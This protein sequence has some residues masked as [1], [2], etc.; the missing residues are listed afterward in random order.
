VWVRRDTVDFGRRQRAAISPLLSML[1][2]ARKHA[3]TSNPRAR[4]VT[5]CRSAAALGL[6]GAEARFDGRG[7]ERMLDS[8]NL[9]FDAAAGRSRLEDL[10]NPGT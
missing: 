8:P 6:R 4:A 7:D 9:D 10:T 2:P 3:S 5:K 1:S